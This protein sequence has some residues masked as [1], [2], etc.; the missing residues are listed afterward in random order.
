MRLFAIP[1]AA[2]AMACVTAQPAR[3]ERV[4]VT[5]GLWTA[6]SD[7]SSDNRALCGITT[8]GADGRRITVRQFSGQGGVSVQLVKN[9]WVIPNDTSVDLR[10]QFDLNEQVPARAV[11]GGQ[12]LTFGLNFD[13]SVPFMR[14]LRAGSQMRVFFLTGNEPVWTGGLSGSGRAIDAFNDCRS[15]L[16][17]MQPTQPFAAGPAAAPAAPPPPAAPTQPFASGPEPVSPALAPTGPQQG[18]D[19]PPIP[20]APPPR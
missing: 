18:A 20:L 12:Q 17:P 1:L 11:G 16:A 3:A 10:L 15:S 8:V 6:F 14:S 19:L 9:S 7:T 13:Q 5:A 4:L 2:A